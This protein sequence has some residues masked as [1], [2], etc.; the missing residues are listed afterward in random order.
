[1]ALLGGARSPL[2]VAP[3]GRERLDAAPGRLAALGLPP[4]RRPCVAPLHRVSTP[5]DSA[6]FEAALAAWL[7]RTGRAPSAKTGPSVPEAVAIDRPGL[8]G[9][10]PKRESE[11][12]RG[13][14]TELVA[15]DAHGSGRGVGQRRAAGTGDELAAAKALLNQVPIEGRVVTADARLTQR[16]ISAQ[17][18]ADGGA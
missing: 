17:I 7:L 9:S 14:G 10:Q 11:P 3:W 18:V 12:D 6:A 15:A 16:D 13:S 1:V 5:V 2:A 8:R 4:G